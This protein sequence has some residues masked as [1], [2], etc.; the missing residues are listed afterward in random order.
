MS[1]SVV[2]NLSLTVTHFGLSQALEM[3]EQTLKDVS[4]ISST[5]EWLSF[6]HTAFMKSFLLSSDDSF[7]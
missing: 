7:V 1:L 6:F 2:S 3:I 5:I 4:I